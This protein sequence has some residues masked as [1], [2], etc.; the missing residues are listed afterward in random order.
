MAG[1][2]FGQSESRS[3]SA[4]DSFIP[5]YEPQL[6]FLDQFGKDAKSLMDSQYGW[7]QDQFAKNSN[8]TDFDINQYLNG[9]GMASGQA[10]RDYGSY[11]AYMPD[12]LASLDADAR[13]YA[14]PDRIASEMGRSEADVAQNFDAQRQN[15]ERDLQSYGIDPSAG[16][17]AGQMSTMRAQQGAAEAG[18]GN[19]ARLATEATGRALRAEEM[20]AL[21]RLP[22]QAVTE[23]N[24]GYQGLTGAQNA[25]FGNTS[26]GALTL[27]TAPQYLKSGID[28]IKFQPLGTHASSSSS[29]SS[30]Q[31][32]GDP[33]G[34]TAKDPPKTP[35]KEEQSP[36]DGSGS[37]SGGGGSGGGG[38]GSG[39]RSAAQC[40]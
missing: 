26:L 11:N 24:V 29:T 7:A 23:Q 22:G 17:F 9:A 28:D 3:R 38:S 18:A 32:S 12:Q 31:S 2:S 13:S 21:A 39:G 19:Q 40:R 37:G 33:G 15:L 30:M 25:A 16:R 6:G 36:K 34:S 27:G 10:A 20:N 1:S 4:S 5:D 14:S 35:Q 8:L